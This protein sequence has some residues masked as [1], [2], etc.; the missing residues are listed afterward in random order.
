MITFDIR[1]D[2]FL[3]NPN[4]GTNS[5]NGT[6]TV[7]GGSMPFPADYVIRVTAVN[8]QPTPNELNGNSGITKLEVFDAQGNL[9]GAYVPMNPGQQASIQGDLS[10]VGDNYLR[11]NANVLVPQQPNVGNL[12]GLNS[13]VLTNGENDFSSLPVTFEVGNGAYDILPFVPPIPC[14]TRGTQIETA[15]GIVA[16]EDLRPGDMILTRDHGLQ[17]L[18]WIGSRSLSSE[19]LKHQ[20]ELRPIRV[21]AGALGNDT[22]RVDLMVSPQHRILVRSAIAQ[23]MFGADEILVAAKQ[24]LQLDGVDI[25]EDATG[26]E[27]FHMLF[28]RHEIVFSNGAET[29]SLYT[30]PEALKSVGRAAQNEIFALFPQLRMPDQQ[31]VPARM[32]VSG[33]Q[34][35]RLAMRHGQNHKALVD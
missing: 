16:I 20:P 17:P 33:R 10:G 12:P 27:Y 2:Q 11:F 14:F 24:F 9:V 15:D 31:P 4:I 34:G 25:A 22:P 8:P 35:R 5:G 23:R 18:R 26:V 6:A 3:S 30:G 32:L 28:D 13:A 19:T 7:Q 1:G 29:E 21:K